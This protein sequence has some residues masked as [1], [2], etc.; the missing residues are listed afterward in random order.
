MV[1]EMHQEKWYKIRTNSYKNLLV[2]LKKNPLVCGQWPVFSVNHIKQKMYCT[3]S[4]TLAQYAFVLAQ[5]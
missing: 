1:L 2:C 5:C 3:Y 4:C